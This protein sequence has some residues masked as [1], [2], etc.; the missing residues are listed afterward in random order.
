MKYFCNPI[1]INYKYQFNNMSNGRIS[2]SREAADPSMILF[3]DCYYLFPSMSGGFWHSTDLADWQYH[4]LKSLPAYDYAPDVC[5]VGDA[6]IFCASNHE[7]GAFFRTND[8][9]LD[10]FERID[11]AFP[12]WDPKLFCDDDGR[13]FLYWGSSTR[14]PLYGIELDAESL[15]PIGE[16]QSLLAADS[17]VLGYERYGENHLPPHSPEK[18]A[19]MLQQLEMATDMQADLK[20]AARAYILGEPYIEGA[21]L[22]K[23]QGRYYLQY[24]VPSSGQNIY[25]DGVY[26]SECPLG[27]FRPVRNNPF[28]YKPGG[29]SPGAGHGSTLR[30]RQDC[31]WH[32]ATSRIA[33]NHNFERRI[34]LWPAG[35]DQDGEL[36]CNQR[37]GDWPIDIETARLDP[38]ANPQWMLLSY[39]KPSKA[40][41]SSDGADPARVADEDIRT[42]WKAASNEPGE[43]IEIDLETVC[44]VNAVQVN[45]ADDGLAGDLPAGAAMHG[46]LH[47][48]RW[49]DEK[50]DQPTRWLLEGSAD[51]VNYFV[52]ADKTAADTNLPHD[53]IVLPAAVKVR[54]LR[55]TIQSLPYRQAACVSGLRVFGR[56]D[57]EKPAKAENV[58]IQ[59]KSDLDLEV[60]WTGHGTGYVVLW[61]YAPDKLYHSYQVFVEQVNLGGLIKGQEIY[62]RVDSFNGAGITEGDVSKV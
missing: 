29:F 3:K 37:Y 33:I 51:G 16:K 52:L 58:I 41:S 35:F 57:G 53:L 26:V 34:G 2:I 49:I 48:E 14:E 45:F 32:I 1:N 61:G 47:Q 62:I 25:A 44:Q 36:F 6:V 28:S 22:N 23:H 24:A 46:A 12:F 31:F 60:A 39:G 5:V 20:V 19:L 50:S 55:L 30:D 43:W 9:F 38:W 42:W 54:L 13:L 8:L 21:W 27:P 7:Q 18:V 40:S 10:N 59:R 15:Q 56:S 17:T 4:P 11:S